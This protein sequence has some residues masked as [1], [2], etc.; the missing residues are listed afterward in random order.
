MSVAILLLAAGDSTRMGTSKQLLDIGGTPLLVHSVKIALQSGLHPV[1]VVLGAHAEEH[2]RIIQSLPVDVVVHEDW[3]LGMGSSLKA[4]LRHLLNQSVKPEAVVVLVCDQPRLTAQH[5]QALVATYRKERKSI[6]ASRYGDTDGVP[7]LF[8]ESLFDELLGLPDGHGAKKII[9]GHGDVS[10]VG[11][12]EGGIDLD[13]P[14]D[15]EA[16]NISR[17]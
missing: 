17:G 10:R 8:A 14:E 2:R 16:Y 6:V 3:Q 12:D 1:T 13:T 15:Y 7:V 5:I 4:G 11:F 9:G